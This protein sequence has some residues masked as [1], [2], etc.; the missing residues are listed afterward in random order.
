MTLQSPENFPLSR[1]AWQASIVPR[2]APMTL[3]DPPAMA[4]RHLRAA[5]PG[6][7]APASRRKPPDTPK[8]IAS[9]RTLPTIGFDLIR[10]VTYGMLTEQV[11][12]TS[13]PTV[14][15]A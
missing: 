13:L 4:P 2:P 11:I 8:P 5:A 6:G 9:A 10:F 3:R 7:A 12:G 14:S 15:L 1:R